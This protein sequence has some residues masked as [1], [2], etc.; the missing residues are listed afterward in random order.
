MAHTW[1][2]RTL[3]FP[4]GED[5]SWNQF[6]FVKLYGGTIKLIDAADDAVLGVLQNAPASGEDATVLYEGTTKIVANA[7]LAVDAFVKPEYVSATDNGKAQAAGTDWTMLR[8]KVL[9]AA[10]AEDDLAVIQLLP[11]TI[12]VPLPMAVQSTVTAITTADDVAYTIAQMLG[13][14]ITRNPSGGARADTTPT[15][16]EIIAGMKQAGVG[17]SFVFA[18]MNTATAD[19]TITL[20]AGDG[21]VTVADLA[22]IGE[23]STKMFVV[24]VTSGTEVSIYN[25]GAQ[26]TQA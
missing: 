9:I 26:T 11:D 18:I 12:P 8:G 5:L 2:G 7:A 13:G 25:L 24:Q 10:G 1:G 23:N 6:R 20:T 15:A 14:M 21:D 19:E 22:T 3:A 4:A 17:S 16:A